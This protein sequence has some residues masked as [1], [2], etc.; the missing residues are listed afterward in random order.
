ME[1][2]TARALE[3]A[4][5][6]GLA[7]PAAV[8]L[9]LRRYRA[10]PQQ[11]LGEVIGASLARALAD[12]AILDSPRAADWLMLLVEAASLS[13]DERIARTIA[14]LAD[15][16]R[17][18]WARHESVEA[19]TGSIGACLAAADI[20]PP[21]LARDAIDELERALGATYRPGDGLA[22]SLVDPGAPRGRLADHVRAAGTLLIA[23]A[24]T[25]RLPYAMLADELMQFAVRCLWDPAA[26]GFFDCPG[27]ARAKP[28]A[29]N[30]DAARVLCRLA[31]LHESERYRDTAVLAPDARYRRNA[32]ATLDALSLRY[33]QED[34]ALWYGVALTEAAPPPW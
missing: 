4:A 26:G 24:L 21:D 5:R 11:E 7:N 16:L 32:E 33:R 23:H 13:D 29:A 2:L 12:R 34:A 17:G 30:C 9:L 22:S 25:D 3:D 27:A 28:F 14:D 1:W 10:A 6:D 15:A 31:A 19:L 8:T 20:G 18:G